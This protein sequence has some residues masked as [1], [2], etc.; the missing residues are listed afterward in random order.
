MGGWVGGTVVECGISCCMRSLATTVGNRAAI[1]RYALAGT[2]RL[3]LSHLSHTRIS[4]S[5]ASLSREDPPDVG[6]KDHHAQPSPIQPL[7]STTGFS[8]PCLF[9]PRVPASANLG[10]TVSSLN[11]S[12]PQPILFP[13]THPEQSRRTLGTAFLRS[14]SGSILLGQS[15]S[16]RTPDLA[17]QTSCRLGWSSVCGS[18]S[19]LGNTSGDR[20][21][22]W[23]QSTSGYGSSRG[24]S[25]SGYG[26]RH[27]KFLGGR[28]VPGAG[29]MPGAEMTEMDIQEIARIMQLQASKLAEQAMSMSSVGRA[30]ETASQG[31]TSS[32]ETSKMTIFNH[33][34]PTGVEIPR[35]GL[36]VFM[37]SIHAAAHATDLPMPSYASLPCPRPAPPRPSLSSV[38]LRA[39]T[40]LLSLAR[41]LERDWHASCP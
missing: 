3:L 40:P 15:T 25:T 36:G 27:G 17:A 32:P 39:F 6:L 16:T 19:A 10:L 35:L 18:P 38:G 23:H 22:I 13:S 9:P 30:V 5:P 1:N 28:R 8:S 24:L 31:L 41:C 4:P 33:P 34:L 26:S 11:H 20:R 37:V 12:R 2:T 14:S 21:S 29:S 7:A